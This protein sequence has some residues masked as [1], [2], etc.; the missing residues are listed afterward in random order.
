M[1]RLFSSM[2][3]GQPSK[4]IEDACTPEQ[5]HPSR[6]AETNIPQ[7]PFPTFLPA[8]NCEASRT[9]RHEK[10]V[11]EERYLIIDDSTGKATVSLR[12]KETLSR[13]LCTIGGSTF[14]WRTA[15]PAQAAAAV[16]AQDSCLTNQQP[17]LRRQHFRRADY[18]SGCNA[19]QIGNSLSKTP[20]H[21]CWAEST[22]CRKC[23]WR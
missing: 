17:Q 19:L 18:R 7:A 12:R 15:T 5:P 11:R 10:T 4:L 16:Y 23:T 8:E 20:R 9:E 6:C 2:W 1:W 3:Q 22:R 21:R 13:S 14:Q